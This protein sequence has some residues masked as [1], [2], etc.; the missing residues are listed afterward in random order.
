LV[1]FFKNISADI[2]I[3]PSIF[4]KKF[5]QNLKI[6]AQRAF[7]DRPDH[8]LTTFFVFSITKMYGKY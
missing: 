5:P 6:Y 3:S 2:T 8:K 4:L 7:S 1:N